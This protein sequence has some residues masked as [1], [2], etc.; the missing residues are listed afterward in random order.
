[1]THLYFQCS[2][3]ILTLL[4]AGQI[5][6][7]CT[8]IEARLSLDPYT[9]DKQ[10]RNAVELLAENY[11]DRK[12]NYP[13]A[14]AVKKQP[15]FIFTTDGCSRAP[16]D[17]WVECCIVHDIPYWCGGSEADRVAADEFL[18]QC[19]NKQNGFFSSL[20]YTGVRL[21]GSPWLPTPWRWGY[22]WEVWPHDYEPLEHSPSVIQLLED[23]SVERAVKE[24]LQK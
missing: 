24:H 13:G 18:Q 11:C 12:R 15:D 9:K 14:T 19:V 10:K 5:L 23:L 4:I 3:R 1:M 6:S 21:G 8:T 7:A 16:D 2:L 17:G 22:G 20:F